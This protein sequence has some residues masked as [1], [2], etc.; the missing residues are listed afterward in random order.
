[1]EKNKIQFTFDGFTIMDS[2]HWLSFSREKGY[3]LVFNLDL[4]IYDT[5]SDGKAE[6]VKF[7]LCGKI[8]ERGN[9]GT[10]D[11]FQSAD[12]ILAEQFKELEVEEV[13]KK[14]DAEMGIFKTEEEYHTH[15]IKQRLSK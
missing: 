6:K 13:K 12:Q 7:G 9:E 4:M 15:I 3:D 5:N 11:I 2:G 8:Y 10:D 1:M 14:W